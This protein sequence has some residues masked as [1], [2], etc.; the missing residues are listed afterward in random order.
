[1]RKMIFLWLGVWVFSGIFLFA[2]QDDEVLKESV[3]VVNVEVPVRVYHKGKP[4]DNLTR[5]DFKL[6]EGGKR[7]EIHGF[8]LRR[9]KMKV[10][11]LV[12]AAEQAQVQKSRYFV[13]VFRITHYNDYIKDGLDHIFN[14]V[15]NEQDQL[16]V[17]VND[18]S[19]FFESLEDKPAVKSEL[20]RL[21]TDMSREA[22]NNVLL[23]LKEVE[24]AVNKHKMEMKLASVYA[25]GKTDT[26]E[27]KEFHTLIQRYFAKFLE[28][29]KGY[30][31]KYLIPDINRYYNFARFLENIKKEKWVINFYQFEV[32]PDIIIDSRSMR[33]IRNIISGLQTSTNPEHI[34]F[35]RIISRQINE[36]EKELSVAKDFP[37]EEVAKIFHNVDATF[38]SIFMKTSF[39]TLL[40]DME[41]REIASDLE[42]S[43]RAITA[44]TGGELVVS[45]KLDLALDKISDVEDVSYMLTYAPNNPDNVGKI[46]IKLKNRKYKLVYSPNLK[47]G[48]LGQF[49]EEKENKVSPIKI[50]D[51]SFK[52]G[53]LQ[54]VISDF[55]WNKKDGGALSIR[56]RINNLQGISVF[57]QKKTIKAIQNNIN[58]S[59]NLPGLKKGVYDVMVDVTDL[60]TKSSSTEL[61]KAA[62]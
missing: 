6:Y 9:K 21:L 54:F 47:G 49:L 55:F 60:F 38:H 43:L 14:S 57:D 10:Q 62:I 51:L 50:Q 19:Q 58:I 17:F 32:F 24:S 18:R 25:G 40:K 1:M 36:I 35:S 59:L 31:K 44:R 37:S 2:R 13:L 45:N 39:N 16:L 29:W 20:D 34:T 30:K 12:M 52:K 15:L 53:K 61:L 11:E 5:E 8:I 48:Y 56:I 22:R 27:K 3:Q 42:N 26:G 41:Y 7:Q 4:V 46:K 23:Y 28:I 33:R